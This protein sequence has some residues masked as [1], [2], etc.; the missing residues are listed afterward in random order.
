MPK[1][2]VL[3]SAHEWV[4]LGFRVTPLHPGYKIPRYSGWQTDPM[5][6]H[7]RVE[8]HWAAFPEDNIGIVTTGLLVLD[9]D[10]KHGNDGV[11]KLRGLMASYGTLPGT[12]VHTTPS[13]GRHV[14]LRPSEPVPNRVGVYPGIDV[15]GERGYVVAPPSSTSLGT[16]G[17][18]ADRPL[19]AA[20]RWVM[21]LFGPRP[22]KARPLAVG[23]VATSAEAWGRVQEQAQRLADAAEGVGNDTA[24]RV[25]FMVGQYV[26]AGQV[27]RA[28]AEDELLQALSGWT[29]RDRR[30]HQAM[31]A[32]IR[33]GL[34]RGAASPRAWIAVPELVYDPLDLPAG[35]AEALWGAL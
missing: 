35:G 4:S 1:V 23:P 17:V 5:D 2:T 3:H 13:D 6:D 15:R 28:E 7:E 9:L 33:R 18:L 14:F 26:G 19:A 32:T 12:R 31:R 11:E 34:D 25:S 10:R 16:Y 20:P 22:T 24:A 29:W 27:D 21:D 8:C 30:T